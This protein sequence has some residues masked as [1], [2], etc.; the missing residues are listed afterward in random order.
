MWEETDVTIRDPRNSRATS[1]LRDRFF[2]RLWA[3]G[4]DEITVIGVA[5]TSASL[6]RSTALLSAAFRITVPADLTRGIVRQIDAVAAEEW[7]SARVAI[8]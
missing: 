3:E 2:D 8:V 5:P 4:V 6:G 1:V 7:A